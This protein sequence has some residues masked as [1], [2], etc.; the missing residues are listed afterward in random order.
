MILGVG[1]AGVPFLL[2]IKIPF[3]LLLTLILVYDESFR[4]WPVQRGS[5]GSTHCSWNLGEEGAVTAG[6]WGKMWKNITAFQIKQIAASSLDDLWKHFLFRNHC[7]PQAR[8]PTG[9]HWRAALQPPIW[10]LIRASRYLSNISKQ[11]TYQRFSIFERVMYFIF[12]PC[13]SSADH[14]E[15][16]SRHY[17][18][19]LLSGFVLQT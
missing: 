17:W 11:T 8:A 9:P 14:D 15:V 3:I 5:K 4:S 12:S 16:V 7:S 13:G 1:G 6:L 19:F 10:F 2:S 18:G